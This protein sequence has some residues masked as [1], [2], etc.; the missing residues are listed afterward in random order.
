MGSLD[1]CMECDNAVVNPICPECLAQRMRMVVGEKDPELARHI[2]GANTL[3]ET[4][5]IFCGKS[6]GVCAPCFSRDIY[7]FIKERNAELADNFKAI[8]DFDLRTK[9]VDFDRFF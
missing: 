3:G 6:V 1:R 7:E 9:I 5:C 8:F 4:K 2:T